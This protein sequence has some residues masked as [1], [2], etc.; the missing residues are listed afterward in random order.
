MTSVSRGA[1]HW[2][3]ITVRPNSCCGTP[4]VVRCE[5]FQQSALPLPGVLFIPVLHVAEQAA[6]RDVDVE[7]QVLCVPFSMVCILDRTRW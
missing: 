2:I 7:Q 6:R 5:V 4:P 1:S 3:T